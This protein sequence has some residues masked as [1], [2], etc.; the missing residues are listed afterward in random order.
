MPA[1]TLPK[2]VLVLGGGFAGLAFCK[3][4]RNRRFQITLVDRQNHHLFQP[5]LYQ[6]ATG[7][8][9]APDIAQPLRSILSERENVTTL[10]DDVEG[11]ELDSRQV[12]CRTRTLDYDYLV[13]ALGAKTGYF[14]HG[15]WASHAVGLKSLDDAMELRRRILLAFERAETS[16]NPTDIERLLTFVIVGGGPTGVEMAGAVAELARR[17]MER[18]FRRIDP[19]KARIHLIESGPRLLSMFSDELA[20][21]ATGQLARMGVTVHLNCAVRDV[22]PGAV[23]AG[24]LRLE[25]GLV[26]WAAGVE[27]SQIARH[28]AGVPVDRAG[29]IEVEADLSLPGH[30]EVFAAGDIVSLVDKNGVRVPGV[31]PAAIQMGRHIAKIIEH[32]EQFA[33]AAKRFATR[34]PR[35][36]F[37]YFDKGNMATIGRSHAIAAA[38]GMNFRGFVAWLMWLF[39]HLLFLVGFRNKASVFFTWVWSYF[40]W[41]RGARIVFG[42]S[43]GPKRVED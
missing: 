21:Y 33:A 29:R 42:L 27:A 12:S 20:D 9:S 40:T 4:L 43:G 7:G 10:M 38:F 26:I 28:L 30:P 39:I 6:V 14:G 16:D 22:E 3:T 23:V 41:Q 31:A 24:T 15:K 5:L 35:P 8:L 32:D 19:T 34:I 25:A 2:K 37:T 13:I 11:I 17:V 18:D 36:A 1:T